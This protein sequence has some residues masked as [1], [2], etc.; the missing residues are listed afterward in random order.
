MLQAAIGYLR[1]STQEQGRSGL[2]LAS[3]R[4]EIEQFA[5]RKGFSVNS[6]Y[7]D[8]QTGAG[9]D[10]LQFVRAWFLLFSLAYNFSSSVG[11]A[12]CDS[13]RRGTGKESF[14][15]HSAAET[16]SDPTK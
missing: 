3:Q 6:W 4:F 7:Q 13:V 5:K 8:V 16:D 12:F 10:A 1:V 9:S 14:R 2:G 15:V 11:L